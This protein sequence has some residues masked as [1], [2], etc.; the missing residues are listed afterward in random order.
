AARGHDP[1]RRVARAAAAA[2]RRSGVPARV[3]PLLRQRRRVADQAGLRAAE[4]RANL[5]GA[6][7]AAPGLRRL[8]ARAALVLV[9]DLMTTGASLAEA[10]RAVT[11][12][13]GGRPPA[14]VVTVRLPR[15]LSGD[16]RPELPGESWRYF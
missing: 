6:L 11:A 15:R 10:A 12:G 7:E 5:A 2:L 1:V 16:A 3:L 8:T 9:D 4:R 13:G 14:A